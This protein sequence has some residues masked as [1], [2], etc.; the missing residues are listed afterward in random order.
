MFG[1]G[2]WEIMLILVVALIFLGP[3]KLPEIA[4]SLGKGV[5]S[6]RGAMSGIEREINAATTTANE[7][8]R[9]VDKTFDINDLLAEDETPTST[10]ERPGAG[11]PDEEDQGIEDDGRVAA[12]PFNPIQPPVASESSE[13]VEEPDEVASHSDSATEVAS[14]MEAEQTES[15]SRSD[16]QAG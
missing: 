3:N 1:L 14:A 12:D 5:R 11:D 7:Y 9:D 4:K 2:T 10:S 13:P 15:D 6:L 8:R 16:T